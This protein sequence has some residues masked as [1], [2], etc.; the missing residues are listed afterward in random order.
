VVAFAQFTKKSEKA[1]A[2]FWILSATNLFF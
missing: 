2:T 1:V